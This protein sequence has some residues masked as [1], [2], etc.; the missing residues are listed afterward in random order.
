MDAIEVKNLKTVV[1]F[2]NEVQIFREIDK[3]CSEIKKDVIYNPDD[4][5]NYDNSKTIFINCVDELDKPYSLQN[6]SNK[7]GF[8]KFLELLGIEVNKYHLML[9][10]FE[11]ETISC[12]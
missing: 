1:V 12:S 6:S 11:L 9:N 4:C 10:A 8:I 5:E 2:S 7:S 3:I